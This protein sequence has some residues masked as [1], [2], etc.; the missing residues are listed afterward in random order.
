MYGD[1]G[2]MRRRAGQ[3]REQGGDIRRQADQL[4][5]QMDAIAWSGRAADAMRE[6]IRDRASQLRDVASRHDRAAESL[7]RHQHEVESLKE[8]IATAQHRAENLAA[9]A[10]ERLDRL[11]ADDR[12]GVHREPVD[13][14]R[15][16]AG[17][18]PPPPGHKDWLTVELP[19][20]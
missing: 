6:R 11:A 1:T 19:G 9:D 20:L 15:V 17:F 12:D 3:L 16:L 5:S 14:D 4:V 13:A 10:Q 18:A 2:V 7:E 8:R